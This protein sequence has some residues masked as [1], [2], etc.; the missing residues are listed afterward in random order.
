MQKG[1]KGPFRAWFESHSAYLEEVGR[2]N[3]IP[4]K[5]NEALS[6][7]DHEEH[8]NPIDEFRTYKG[9]EESLKTII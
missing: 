8:E 9:I 7:Y 1:F 5:W 4:Q 3:D 2:M 6:R